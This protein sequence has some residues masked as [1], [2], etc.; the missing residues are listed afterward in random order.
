MRFTLAATA[1]GAAAA[2]PA[3]AAAEPHPDA[4][5]IR[6]GEELYQRP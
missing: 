2:I 4:E 6:L 1:A 3:V 5:L